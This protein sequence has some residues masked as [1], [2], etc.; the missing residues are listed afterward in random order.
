MI[1]YFSGKNGKY[2]EAVHVNICK[3]NDETCVIKVG[4]AI[5]FKLIFVATVNAEKITPQIEASWHWL[6]PSKNLE[7]AKED[8]NACKSITT[9]D[10]A[11]GCP[12][13]AGQKYKYKMNVPVN[14]LPLT[15][16]DVDVTF[17]LVSN[18]GLLSCFLFN[19]SL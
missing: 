12:V 4:K 3:S 8:Q 1:C 10:G 14:S 18:R 16:I 17:N 19:A 13:I 2:P 6:L 9:L 7:I 5:E 11:P 15:G